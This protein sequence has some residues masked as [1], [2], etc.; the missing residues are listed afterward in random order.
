LDLEF[1]YGGFHQRI[2]GN[3]WLLYCWTWPGHVGPYL[4]PTKRSE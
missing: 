4:R 2:T 3:C 1:R